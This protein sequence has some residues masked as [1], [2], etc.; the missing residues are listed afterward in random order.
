VQ[1]T[2]A[3]IEVRMTSTRL[4]GKV[5]RRVVGKPL[6]ELLIERLR[7]AVTLDT[8]VVATTTNATD[9]VIA[10]LAERIGVGCYRGSEDDVLDRVLEAARSVSA[11]TIV[12]VTGDCPLMDPQVVDR[13]VRTL[14]ERGCDY[15]SNIL[16]RTFPRGLDVQAFKTSVLERV[17]E[18]TQDP[19]DHEHVSLYIYE[20]PELFSLASVVSGLP[21][22]HADLRLT[23]DTVDDLS[24]ISAV[25]EELYPRNPSF[26]LRD[27]VDMA[28]RRPD[29]LAQNASVSQKPVR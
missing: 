20:H 8:I 1:R 11:S 4:P 24:V 19:V 18:L 6:L 12:E 28:D 10:E 5:L 29:V 25:F 14:Y 21:A 23:V 16:E 27:I 7:Q 3:I 17:A 13:V 15:A 9:D 2:A 26:G 22:R